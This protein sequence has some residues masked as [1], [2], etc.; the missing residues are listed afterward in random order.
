MDSLL[1]Q[2]IEAHGG[3]DRWSEVNRIAARLTI[4]GP[5]W[6]AKGQPGALGAK[7][8]D[9]DAHQ[10]RIAL[11]PFGAADWDLE[12]IVDPEHVIISDASETVVEERLD[13]H[14]SFAGLDATSAWDTLQTGYFIGYSLWNCLTAPFLLSYPD[15]EVREIDPW[16]ES[17]ETWRRLQVRFPSAIATHNPD[18]VFYFD[19]SGMQR[20]IDYALEVNGGSPIAH[21]SDEAKTFNGLVAP[22]R[23]RVTRRLRNG[24]G[25]PAT[26]YITVDIHHIQYD[27]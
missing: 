1:S 3:L 15:V 13:P 7:T 16:E 26:T 2:V 6:A 27:G 12:F 18:Q 21:Y 8:V 22:T 20:R 17:N 24:K 25:D 10:E 5:F 4:G 23:H 19:Q 9:A 11:N 14:A